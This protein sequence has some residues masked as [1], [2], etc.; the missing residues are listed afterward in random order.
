M[1]KEKE[2]REELIEVTTLKGYEFEDACEEILSRCT[3][4]GESLTRTTDEVGRIPGS[5]KGDFVI[6]LENGRKIVLEVKDRSSISLKT[7]K[8]ELKEAI[9]NREAD[10]GIFV[11]K[12][13]EALPKDVG[14]FN[15]Y[16]NILVCALGSS[17]AN[18]FHPEILEIAYQWAKLRLK[19]EG[20]VDKEA[21][22][23]AI[24]ELDKL[25]D[26]LNELSKI[27]T[28]CSNARKALDE[29]ENIAKGLENSLKDQLDSLKR[30]LGTIAG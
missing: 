19:R 28:K 3:G 30:A 25:N 14:W 12:Y 21:V 1:L 16:G 15:E 29:I 2:S 26:Q 5:R 22:E 11:S 9:E 18:S 27:K 7:I 23:V 8:E 6:E 13:K 17:E 10:Y 24:S 20:E 4:F